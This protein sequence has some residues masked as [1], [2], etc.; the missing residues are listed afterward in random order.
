MSP[1]SNLDRRRGLQAAF[2]SK[3]LDERLHRVH[4][5]GMH[6]HLDA[7]QAKPSPF[8]PDRD[9]CVVEGELADTLA[10]DLEVEGTPSCADLQHLV[11]GT[12]PHE[13][14][15]PP[16][17]GAGA[18]EPGQARRR[19]GLSHLEAAAQPLRRG[20][21]GPSASLSARPARRRTRKH[22]SRPA[23]PPV[24]GVDV[25]VHESLGGRRAR[26]R[27]RA[28]GSATAGAV[29]NASQRSTGRRSRASSCHST[30][31]SVRDSPG[32]G[33]TTQANGCG[34]APSPGPNFTRRPIGPTVGR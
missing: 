15:H 16:S 33:H 27:A 13:G 17:H 28:I 31:M 25:D 19:Q 26:S 32:C 8:V 23:H 1:A 24:L 18:V 34:E 30:S 29:R 5:G 2:T 6:L 14:L 3:P 4:P 9:D 7:G 11:E 22:V 12:G 20:R 21:K 10:V